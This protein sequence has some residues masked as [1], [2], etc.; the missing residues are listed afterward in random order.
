MNNAHALF[1]T[2]STLL[3]FYLNKVTLCPRGYLPLLLSY[4][5]VEV[6]EHQD[7]RP[8]KWRNVA[9]SKSIVQS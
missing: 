7:S 9:H 2:N 6:I 1:Y 5:I 8:V 4:Q 3:W